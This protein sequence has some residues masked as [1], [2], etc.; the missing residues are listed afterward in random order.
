MNII[1]FIFTVC[2]IIKCTSFSAFMFKKGNILTTVV[3]SINILYAIYLSVVY[4]FH[5]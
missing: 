5:L 1:Y 4:F 3:M 2:V